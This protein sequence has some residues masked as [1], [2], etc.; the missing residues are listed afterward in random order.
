MQFKRCFINDGSCSNKIIA[1]HTLSQAATMSLIKG[2]TRSGQKV[3]HMGNKSENGKFLPKEIG[4]TN[5]SAYYCFC[6]AHDNE[7]FR[8]IENAN[9]F[10][11]SNNE[12]LFLHTYRS[13]A[14]SYYKK[15]KEIDPENSFTDGFTGTIQEC[16]D[17]FFPEE[18]LKP[19]SKEH[20]KK[21]SL[22]IQFSS[23]ER[24][25]LRLN[26][27]LY[28]KQYSEMAFR[29]C[30]IPKKYPIASAGTLMAEI[31]DG[32]TMSTIIL[33]EGTPIIHKQGLITTILP[34]SQNKTI[35]IVGFFRKDLNALKIIEKID[36]LK[37]KDAF[38]KAIT[39]IILTS[40]RE[41]TFIH[42]KLW[43][44][45]LEK[46]LD[47]QIVLELN[48]D[49]PADLLDYPIYQSEVNLF[50]SDFSCESLGIS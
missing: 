6:G 42:P 32:K 39:G 46:N 24:I 12:H 20:A 40:N 1:A 31:S 18:L 38:A 5:A 35:I 30:I 10:D 29:V 11:P 47:S 22:H 43:E 33:D 7:V 48:N 8:P 45:V 19:T 4:W 41:N 2:T 14:Y 16:S 50:S 27:I 25:K 23:Y 17:M 44:A 37:A 15:K 28:S 49:R 3:I 13:F 34:I 9:V 21:I 26:S 36:R